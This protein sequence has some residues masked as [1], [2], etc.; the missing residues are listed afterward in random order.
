MLSV[1]IIISVTAVLCTVTTV[2]VVVSNAGGA[3][4]ANGKHVTSTTWH[5]LLNT[6]EEEEEELDRHTTCPGANSSEL[7][8]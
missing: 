5:R 7:T 6:E 3:T 8:L 4:P 1:P 2:F